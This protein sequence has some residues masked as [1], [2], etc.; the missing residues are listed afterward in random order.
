MTFFSSCLT[1]NKGFLEGKQLQS[2]LSSNLIEIEGGHRA[3]LILVFNELVLPRIKSS[4]SLTVTTEGEGD[5][6]PIT[7][8]SVNGVAVDLSLLWG[9]KKN[10]QI[11]PQE[12]EIT[13]KVLLA[14]LKKNGF[15]SPASSQPYPQTFH[16]H[17]PEDFQ[18]FPEYGRA[19]ESD[20]RWPRPF[21]SEG[22]RGHAADE[23]SNVPYISANGE[24]FRQE[25]TGAWLDESAAMPDLLNRL[26]EM[27]ADNS[28]ASFTSYVRQDQPANAPFPEAFS[29]M[30]RE[31]DLMA[32]AIGPHRPFQGRVETVRM[33]DEFRRQNSQADAHNAFVRRS[34]LPE[35]M[36]PRLTLPENRDEE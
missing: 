23:Q 10:P 35:G 32:A 28:V 25:Y 1:S 26:S 22:S 8:S 4:L 12:I 7:A 16:G 29:R 30:M 6:N 5:F 15:Q 33:M 14:F 17:R 36:G 20:N 13:D 21:G 3:A 19:R 24:I 34:N 11:D 2:T 9:S 31:R 18:S 27:R